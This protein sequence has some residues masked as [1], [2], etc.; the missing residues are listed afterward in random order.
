MPSITRNGNT[1]LILASQY[2]QPS[3]IRT[4]L[5]HG[6]E[7]NLNTGTTALLSASGMGNVVCVQ[8]HVDCVQLLLDNGA[9]VSLSHP[10]TGH[11]P[12]LIASLMG[13][14][15]VVSILLQHGADAR[16]VTF[17]GCN[18]LHLASIMGH[19]D[20][21]SILLRHGADNPLSISSMLGHTDFVS[22]LLRHG[23]DT[24]TVLSSMGAL[25]SCLR[26]H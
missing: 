7:I 4:L 6:A 26:V 22:I 10:V 14:T 21:V 1:A 5:A 11:N 2:G 15:N 19:T 17:N 9:D 20:V 13:H 25:L 8:G 3:A 24:R 16:T 18:S 23:A 12:L